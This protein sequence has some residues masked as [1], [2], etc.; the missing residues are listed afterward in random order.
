MEQDLSWVADLGRFRGTKYYHRWSALTSSVMTDGAHFV[1]QKAQCFWLFDEIDAMVRRHANE[2]GLCFDN[3]FV[4][5]KITVDL[6][7]G[8]TEIKMDNGNYKLLDELTI[9]FSTFPLAR[10]ELW[11]VW[12]KAIGGN[13]AWVHMLP[14]EY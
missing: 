5:F 2:N 10:F 13:G 11:S 3:R 12:T 1:A 14:G 9:E 8:Q 4:G 6:D 7:T